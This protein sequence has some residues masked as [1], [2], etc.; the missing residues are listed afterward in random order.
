MF[1]ASVNAIDKIWFSQCL[2]Q[3][4][5]G[6]AVID[7]ERGTV[8]SGT[9]T[10][11][12]YHFRYNDVG[13][14]H[15]LP[16]SLWLKCGLETQLAEQAAHSMIEAYFFRDLASSLGINVP[17]PYGTAIAPDRSSGI[18][19]YEDLNR[20]P[21]TFG[22]QHTIVSLERMNAILDLLV[23][24]HATHW[25]SPAL[26]Q[27]EW[28]TPGGIIHSNNVADQFLNFWDY[29]KTR[30]RYAQIPESL[31][32][33]DRVGT[34][35]RRLI[36]EDAANPLC[37]V[38]GD[39]HVGNQFY[40]PDGAPGLLD[41]AT[42]MQGHWAWDVSYAII[43]SQPVEQRRACQQEQLGHYLNRLTA[44]GVAAPDFETAWR[45]YARH[46]AWMFLFA[47]CPAELQP[48]EMCIRNAE[49]AAAA[50]TDLGTLDLLLN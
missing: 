20:R 1:P 5:P 4:F 14:R 22:N 18:V 40:D 29:A 28:L 8:I 24:L 45:D 42:V 19:I 32:D 36:S 35:I 43:S 23:T 49:R 2:S 50:I 17:R 3:S 33:R 11:V 12:E 27:W 26:N 31:R 47:L 15:D 21:V 34:A 13:E 44:L 41:W 10:K 6:T 37:I 48:E 38:H 7:L 25:K 46:A 16:P 30:P 39:P 9:A